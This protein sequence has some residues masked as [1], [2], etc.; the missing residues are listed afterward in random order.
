MCGP[1]NGYGVCALSGVCKIPT[2]RGQ[3]RAGVCFADL[4]ENP[5]CVLVS[6]CFF[7]SCMLILCPSVSRSRYWGG[8]HASLSL[9]VLVSYF[10]CSCFLIVLFSCYEYVQSMSF[11]LISCLSHFFDAGSGTW[12]TARFLVLCYFVVSCWY[13]VFAIRFFS[14]SYCIL[15]SWFLVDLI[16][17]F[18]GVFRSF[19][20][21]RSR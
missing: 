9:L 2:Y 14:F 21:C 5:P 12:I 18:L 4:W 16:Y 3:V 15:Y 1:W 11:C 13:L 19:S 6:M 7:W 10:A 17:V 8:A 20:R